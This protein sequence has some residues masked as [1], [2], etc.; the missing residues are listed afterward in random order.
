MA[1]DKST[2]LAVYSGPKFEVLKRDPASLPALFAANISAADGINEFDMDR[3]SVPSGGG[4]AWSVPDLNGEPEAV[5][6]LKGVILFHGDR[7]AFWSVGFD[8]SGG[9]G[10]PD[11]TSVDGRTGFGLIRGEVGTACEPKSRVCK[12]C[13][14]AAWGSADFDGDNKP[15]TKK[16]PQ[17]QLVP[18]HTNGQACT[19]R[20]VVFFLRQGD[21]LPMVV[22]LAPTSIK[23]FNQFMLRLTSRGIPCYGAE[24]GLKLKNEQSGAGIKYSSVA[25]R[26]LSLLSDADAANMAKVAASMK[27]YFEQIGVAPV[28]T[29]GQ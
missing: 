7:R 25:P 17:G 22:D 18:V 19:Q 14:M 28:A 11:C 4:L 27:P 12:T 1:D 9:G 24:V 20:K 6:E 29:N 15:I 10:P 23:S 5:A 16:N 8:E 3:V 13:P 21:I 26:L 2:S